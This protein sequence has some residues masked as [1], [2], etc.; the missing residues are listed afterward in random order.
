MVDGKPKTDNEI[1]LKLQKILLQRYSGLINER[2]TK[3]VGE[4]KE[5]VNKNDLT[6]HALIASFGF[7]DYSFQDKYMSAAQM[8]FNFV[9]DNISTIEFDFGV[10]YWLFP[11]EILT[12]RIAD[13]EDKAIFLCSLLYALGDGNAE[14]VIAELTNGTPHAFV[15]TQIGQKF[16]IL[17]ACQNHDFAQFCGEKSE[18]MGKYRFNTSGIKKF[19]Y[20]FNHE[21]YEQFQ[22]Q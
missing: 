2:E 12:E 13:D 22:E 15:A 18:A 14:V 3:T 21:N 9:R 8:A 11:K 5:M 10:S 4:I 19:L 20:K 16:Y 6:I 7:V 17:D 1:Q